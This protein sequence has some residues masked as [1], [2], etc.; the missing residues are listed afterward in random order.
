MAMVR[1]DDR[2]R[3]LTLQEQIAALIARGPHSSFALTRIGI[4]LAGERVARQVHAQG[5]LV[6][7]HPA[8]RSDA[9]RGR[10]R[11]LRRS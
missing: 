10:P 6:S 1:H 9:R 2:V 7:G 11:R 3:V 4:G 8:G 5:R